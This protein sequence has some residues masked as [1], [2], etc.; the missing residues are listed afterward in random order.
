MKTEECG[1]SISTYVAF[2]GGKIAPVGFKWRGKLYD[3][4][5][6]CASWNKYE[7]EAKL[8]YFTLLKW[9][10]VYEVCF[11]TRSLIWTLIRIHYN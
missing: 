8:I 10:T 5:E 6:V 11:N 9:R 1:E 2:Y 3:K 7:G 4:L